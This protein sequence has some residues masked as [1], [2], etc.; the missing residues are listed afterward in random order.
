MSEQKPLTIVS[1]RGP[2]EFGRSEATGERT[3]RRGGGGLVT[4]LS[5]LVAHRHALWIASAMTDEDMVVA[6]E[7]DGATPMELDDVTYEVMMVSHDPA[8]YERFYNVIAN[9]ILWFI[10]HY[11]WDLSNA[12]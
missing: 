10:Q 1:N 12:P 2:A 6:N 3:V 11:L 5:G 8:A 7:S 9:P 4:A